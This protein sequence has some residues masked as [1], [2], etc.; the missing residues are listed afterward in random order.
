MCERVQCSDVPL[1]NN[2]QLFGC[3]LCEF[4]AAELFE[5]IQTNTKSNNRLRVCMCVR[6]QKHSIK[7]LL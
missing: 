6:V 2:V 7:I 4:T 1:T 5:I 3:Y